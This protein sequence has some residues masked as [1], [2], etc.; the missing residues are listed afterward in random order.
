MLKEQGRVGDYVVWLQDPQTIVLN[1]NGHILCKSSV[2]VCVLGLWNDK[3]P[4]CTSSAL[5]RLAEIVRQEPQLGEPAL[6]D[7][8]KGTATPSSVTP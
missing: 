6:C 3:S 2:F 1:L 8:T 7:I 4:A 5:H